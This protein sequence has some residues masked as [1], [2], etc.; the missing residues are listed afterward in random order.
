MPDHRLEPF[1][2]VAVEV[3]ADDEREL[4]HAEELQAPCHVLAA[5]LLAP[6]D[7]DMG[8]RAPLI[9]LMSVDSP[10]ETSK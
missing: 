7:E 9:K 3:G 10:W 2:V 5:A 1:V 6:V 8:R 4:R